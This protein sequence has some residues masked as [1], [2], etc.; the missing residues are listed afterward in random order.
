MS[1]LISRT[2]G[3]V[4]VTILIGCARPRPNMPLATSNRNEVRHKVQCSIEPRKAPYKTGKPIPIAVSVCNPVDASVKVAFWGRPA[5]F[6][7]VNF[8]ILG[9]SGKSSLVSTKQ[10]LWCGTGIDNIYL[11]KDRT[12]NAVINLL[13]TWEWGGA[14]AKFPPGD[15]TISAHL[16][17]TTPDGGSPTVAESEKSTFTVMAHE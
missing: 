7:V 10:N 1:N 9:P 12:Y 15:Y 16:F 14:K 8:R 11:A 4:M 13:E 17:A 6:P 3:M 2:L 5:H